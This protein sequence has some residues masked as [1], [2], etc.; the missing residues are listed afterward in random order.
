M[1]PTAEH[2]N[3]F[4]QMG[5]DHIH[6]FDSLYKKYLKEMPDG[7]GVK[8]STARKALRSHPDI[9]VVKHGGSGCIT[10][11]DGYRAIRHGNEPAPTIT[12][13]ET[14]YVDKIVYKK[15]WAWA[16]YRAL[17]ALVALGAIAG[18]FYRGI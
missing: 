7:T 10:H 5:S 9:E 17:A 14:R 18:Y 6:T 1:N 3:K 11:T 16:P 2:L 4:V 15:Y 13:T 8:E 12:I